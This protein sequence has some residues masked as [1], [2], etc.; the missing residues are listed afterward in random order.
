MLGPPAGADLAPLGALL[1]AVLS[2]LVEGVE[3]EAAAG[4]PLDTPAARAM[5]ELVGQLTAGAPAELK[6]YLRQVAPVA[7]G[8]V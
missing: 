4:R 3:V 5:L 7:A 8:W 2:T 6:P 1:P